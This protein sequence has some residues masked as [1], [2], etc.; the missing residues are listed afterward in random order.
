MVTDATELKLL[1]DIGTVEQLLRPLSYALNISYAT[2]F[3]DVDLQA[4]HVDVLVQQSVCIH[5][6]SLNSENMLKWE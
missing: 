6:V 4:L 5:F 3:V 1:D 2:V